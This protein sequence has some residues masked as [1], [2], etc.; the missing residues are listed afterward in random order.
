MLNW[1]CPYHCTYCINH[2]YHELY[3]NKY[4]MRR[5]GIR[6]IIEELKYLKKKYSLEFIKFHDED[7]LMR[8]LGNLQEL[9]DAYREEIGIP[10]V[11]ETNPKSVTEDK[12]RLLKNMNCVS[13]SLAIETGDLHLRK[14]LLKRVDSEEDIVRAFSLFREAGIRTSSFNMLGIPFESRETYRRTVEINR[15]ANVQ[16]P[17]ANFFYPFEGTELRDISIKEGFFDPEDQERIVYERNKP[18]LRF[19]NLSER[20]LIEMQRAFVLYIKLPECYE[21]FIRRSETP[22]SLGNRLRK[23]LLEIYDKTVWNNDGWYID[24]GLRDN[25]LKELNEIFHKTNEKLMGQ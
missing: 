21:P 11:I 23:K 14:D 25:Y 7:F 16:Y 6:R 15:K 12:V 10:F 20:E 4:I 18:A 17:N 13:A 8:P 3:D 1:G 2:F 9:S 5:Y 19:A 24:D 22:D